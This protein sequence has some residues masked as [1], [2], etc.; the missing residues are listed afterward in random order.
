VRGIKHSGERVFANPFST[1]VAG[2]IAFA[3]VGE[4]QRVKGP[5]GT[6][7][8]RQGDIE[9]VGNDNHRRRLLFRASPS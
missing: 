9:G 3:I 7:P 6:A 5:K 2:R 1:G 8:E 4:K